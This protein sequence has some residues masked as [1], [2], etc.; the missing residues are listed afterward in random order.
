MMGATSTF[1]LVFML[2]VLITSISLNTVAF[3]V[4]LKCYKK[5]RMVHATLISIAISDILLSI[6]GCISEIVSILKRSIVNEE[7]F[8]CVGSSF[9]VFFSAISVIILIAMFNIVRTVAVVFPLHYRRFFKKRFIQALMIMTCY[10]YAF[11][12][13]VFPVMSW[14]K[15]TV[16]IDQRRCSLDW[17]MKYSTSFS[18]I[19]SVAIFCYVFP[20]AFIV[21]S[22][23]WINIAFK[24]NQKS[25]LRRNLTV[26][27]NFSHRKLHDKKYLKLFMVMGTAFFILWTPYATTAFFALAHKTVPKTL[28]TTAALFAK[29]A[30]IVNPIINC[31]LNKNFREKLMRLKYIKRFL[32]FFLC[33]KLEPNENCIADSLANKNCSRN[34]TEIIRISRQPS[35]NRSSMR[36]QLSYAGDSLDATWSLTAISLLNKREITCGCQMINACIFQTVYLVL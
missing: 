14:S 25:K 15:Y 16:D 29:I 5:V 17:T 36:S 27:D 12:W 28:L 1:I 31:Y 26:K 9:F 18:Y 21:G 4:F 6:S 30:S 23:M 24:L 8:F 7:H 32:S 34:S 22:L 11:L 20:L 2:T 3:W 19:S 35:Y 10:L 13:A 33:I